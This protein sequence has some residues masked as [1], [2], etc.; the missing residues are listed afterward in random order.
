MSESKPSL[1]GEA[2]REELKEVFREVIREDAAIQN[3]RAEK[4]LFDSKE[5]A[6]QLG[7][8]HT[9]LE[10]KAREGKIP[11]RRLGHYV[12]YSREDIEQIA[13]GVVDPPEG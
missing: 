11:C 12:R 10:T 7:V 5:A 9:W 3:G 13:K 2:F 1:F 4:L 8:T 6:A